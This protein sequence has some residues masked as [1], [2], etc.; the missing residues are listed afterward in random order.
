MTSYTIHSTKTPAGARRPQSHAIPR[1]P[2]QRPAVRRSVAANAARGRTTSTTSSPPAL[3]GIAPSA[4]RPVL[5]TVQA[6]GSDS[7]RLEQVGDWLAAGAVGIIPTDS[8]PAVVCDADHRSAALR[9]FDACDLDPKKQLSI[10]VASLSDVALFTT[11]FPAATVAGTGDLFSAARRVLPGPYTF[12]LQAAK[13][14][15]AQV[16][17]RSRNLAKHRRTVGVR[18]PGDSVSRVVVEAM[19]AAKRGAG[20]GGR[21]EEGA[22]LLAHSVH[23]GGGAGGGAKA[24]SW[25]K[26]SS[27]S[28]RK[29][30][31][32][33]HEDGDSMLTVLPEIVP[34]AGELLEAYSRGPAGPLD[35]V[36]AVAEVGSGGGARPLAT[37]STVIDCTGPVPVVVRRGAGDASMFEE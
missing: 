12:I 24:G 25:K 19:A 34:D 16:V 22:A 28:R 10:I 29:G 17:D 20:G 26:G 6:D 3:S 35:F 14:L 37:A 1:P 21:E 33:E 15:P 11:G 7:W 13:R 9:L 32:D 18:L 4:E 2:R 36:V 27:S 31:G 5:V 8:L 30:G 23:G